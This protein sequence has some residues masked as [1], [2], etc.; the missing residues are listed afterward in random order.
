M[1]DAIEIRHLKYIS[2]R[3]CIN[4][5]VVLYSLSA[6]QQ[7]YG[8]QLQLNISTRVHARGRCLK[9]EISL[10]RRTTNHS[11]WQRKRATLR[12]HGPFTRPVN[13]GNVN[14]PLFSVTV[15]AAD[16]DT[17]TQRRFRASF[18]KT[19]TAWKVKC[20]DSIRCSRAAMGSGPKKHF[21][22]LNK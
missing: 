1:T 11:T 9:L 21:Q 3:G 16:G 4:Y 19:R 22:E 8:Y 7:N 6:Y 12:V 15:P 17:L 5:S 2:R 13:S 10:I 18:A 20:Y 14:R